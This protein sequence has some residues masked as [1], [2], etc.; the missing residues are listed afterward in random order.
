MSQTTLRIQNKTDCRFDGHETGY[1]IG[2]HVHALSLLGDILIL[3]QEF[4][5]NYRDEVA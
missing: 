5:P 2:K 1:H 4:T 3:S